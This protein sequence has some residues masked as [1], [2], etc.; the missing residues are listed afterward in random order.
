QVDVGLD[1]GPHELAVERD[2]RVLDL[3]AHPR[4][5]AAVRTAEG[6]RRLPGELQQPE[7][8]QDDADAGEQQPRQGAPSREGRHA[9]RHSPN[10]RASR[11]RGSQRRYHQARNVG[12]TPRWYIASTDP[13]TSRV[14]SG[15]LARCRRAS[16]RTGRSITASRPSPRRR[17]AN[18][19]SSANGW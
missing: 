7:D 10:A 5:E 8:A 3:L 9:V 18:A 2:Q 12:A 13:V 17:A 16:T 14:L 1:H 6:G 15:P 4:A 19:Q 11:W